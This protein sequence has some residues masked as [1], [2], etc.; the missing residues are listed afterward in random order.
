LIMRLGILGGTFDPIHCG[1]IR[2]AEY[3]R[4]KLRLNKIY[5]IPAG[6]PPHKKPQISYDLRVQMLHLALN[7]NLHFEIKE[8]E[9]QE[10]ARNY[11]Y[12]YYTL[13]KLRI[14][15][16]NDELYFLMGEDNVSEISTWFKY[17]EML[18]LAQFII[19]NRPANPKNH[20]HDFS[21]SR[22]LTFLEMPKIDIS[23]HCIRNMCSKGQSIKGLVPDKVED[24]IE[25]NS[26]YIEV[27]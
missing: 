8:L 27:T 10:Q 24:F 11:T 12:T 25:N 17:N 23:S 5:F 2:M 1:H 4:D 7:G 18:N 16:P 26:L 15:H 19:I 9:K 21:F 13:Q 22:E 3:C 6:N 20:S 14:E